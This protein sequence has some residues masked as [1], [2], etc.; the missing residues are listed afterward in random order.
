MAVAVGLHRVVALRAPPLAPLHGQLAGVVLR[1]QPRERGL[2]PG[3]GRAAGEPR[4]GPLLRAG[5]VG[6]VPWQGRSPPD[7]RVPRGQPPYD[8]DALKRVLGG[9]GPDAQGRVAHGFGFHLRHAAPRARGEGGVVQ[10][11]V[12]AR[13]VHGQSHRRRPPGLGLPRAAAHQRRGRGRGRAGG[14]TQG[15]RHPAGVHR[16][17]RPRAHAVE[18]RGRL[19][20]VPLPHLR[21]HAEARRPLWRWQRRTTSAFVVALVDYQGRAGA[22]C[23]PSA[24][25]ARGQVV[26]VFQESR[27]P[28]PPGLQ[29][30]RG[31]PARAGGGG[32]RPRRGRGERGGRVRAAD[33]VDDRRVLRR[34][35]AKLLP[36][37]RRRRG[38]RRAQRHARRQRTGLRQAV[39]AGARPAV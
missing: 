6:A 32:R 18:P 15:A 29:P 4:P 24:R 8:G 21:A 36:R 2:R 7:Q 37:P 1:R 30:P 5:A 33:Q 31:A 28:G 35:A 22:R 17:G 34:R 27:G 38:G 25:L 16:R 14:H 39:H 26:E 13:Q 9:V 11:V 19:R 23:R 3:A 10:L 12:R 20:P